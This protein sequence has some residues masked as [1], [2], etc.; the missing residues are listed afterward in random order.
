MKKTNLQFT[1]PLF[2]FLILFPLGGF[3]QA[4]AGGDSIGQKTRALK[5]ENCLLEAE[6]A[7]ASK[8]TSYIIYH[9]GPADRIGFCPCEDKP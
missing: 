8:G 9:P 6:L 3:S 1:F 5:D 2:L 7:L 4:I